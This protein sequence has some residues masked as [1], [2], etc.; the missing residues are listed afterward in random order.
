MLL[1]HRSIVSVASTVIDDRIA[2]APIHSTFCHWSSDRPLW[3]S[4]VGNH[5]ELTVNEARELL[6]VL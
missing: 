2:R 5:S 4:F 1:H 6:V 3:R